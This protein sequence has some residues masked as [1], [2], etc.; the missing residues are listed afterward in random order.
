MAHANALLIAKGK[1]RAQN[2]RALASPP[3]GERCP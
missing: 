2:F 3:V 1:A